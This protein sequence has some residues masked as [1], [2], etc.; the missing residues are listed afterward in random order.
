[1]VAVAV[2]PAALVLVV[3]LVAAL[4]TLVEVRLLI[5]TVSLWL[6]RLSGSVGLASVTERWVVRVAVSPP[7]VVVRLLGI[8]ACMA[9]RGSGPCRRLVTVP[10]ASVVFRLP[11]VP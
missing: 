3:V 1:M 9:K 10:S 11:L 5:L 8:A 7:V 6:V 4:Y 2:R